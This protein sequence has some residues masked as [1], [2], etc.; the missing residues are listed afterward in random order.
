L[1]IQR[2]KCEILTSKIGKD[3]EELQNMI[4]QHGL[5]VQRGATPL[6]GTVVGTD[7]NEIQ[8]LVVEQVETWKK[9]LELLAC[10]ELPAQLS[11]LIGRWTMTAKPNAL[12]RSLPPNIINAPLADFGETVLKTMEERLKLRLEGEA[13]QLFRLPIYK[14]GV[15]FEPPE[16]IAPYAFLAGVAASCLAFTRTT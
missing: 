14:G 15:G 16:E 10:E 1:E 6:L 11:L 3:S 7:E 9:A 5:H 4:N 12:I 13:R 2:D 8:K